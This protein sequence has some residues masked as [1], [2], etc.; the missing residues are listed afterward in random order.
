MWL[1]IFPCSRYLRRSRRRTRCLLI[2]RILVGIR[3]SLVPRRLPGPMCRPLR[4][5]ARFN[6][7]R[8]REWMATGFLMIKPSLMSFL[9]ACLELA[10]AMSLASLGSSQIRPFPHLET[11]A[12]RRLWSFNDD[13]KEKDEI[14]IVCY[15]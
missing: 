15:K 8:A 14:N 2:H 3:A 7:T 4:L 11:E 5:A 13:Y 6:R 1:S 10:R 9:T 12:A